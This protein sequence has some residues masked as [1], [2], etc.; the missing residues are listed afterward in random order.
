MS[1][2]AR[3]APL[4]AAPSSTTLLAGRHGAAI[5]GLAL[6]APRNALCTRSRPIKMRHAL[7]HP[8]LVI[9]HPLLIP[10]SEPRGSE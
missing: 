5:E 3:R 9:L 6:R 1:C 4:A 8:A 7:T 2:W 10:V